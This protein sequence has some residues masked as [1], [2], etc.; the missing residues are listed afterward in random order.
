[1]LTAGIATG[2]ATLAVRH[3]A[4]R[5]ADAAADHADARARI[6]ARIAAGSAAD[7]ASA[8]A[9]ASATAA[10]A[11]AHASAVS[12]ADADAAAADAAT[13]AGSAHAHRD[14]DFPPDAMLRQPLWHDTGPPDGLRPA[15]IGDTLLDTDPR[16]AFFK[17][18]HDGMDGG[19][20]V[21]PELCLR[22][23]T[24][25]PRE[26]WE[27][28][29]D[30]VAQAI[31]DIEAAWLSEHAANADRAPAFEPDSVAHVFENRIIVSAGLSSLAT[32]IRQEFERFR[33]ETGLN[34]TP[35]MFTPLEALP[36]RLD[37]ISEILQT[38]Q[39]S[40]ETEQTLR[41]EIGRLQ[42]KL[43]ELEA[44][45]A[46]ARTNCEKLRNSS[47]KKVAAYTVAGA[48]LFGVI[49]AA[50]WTVSGDEVGAK[51]RLENLQ[52]YPEVLFGQGPPSDQG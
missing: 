23:A 46:Q 29:A 26:T 5:A 28:G 40:R 33:A 39:Q 6:A 41:E 13:A 44:H 36:P 42:A 30:A 14:A 50:L 10:D 48:N 1:M 35:E 12:A 27:S 34:E 38:L 20:P 2:G 24:K 32:T 19:T 7:A 22:I 17:R 51:K 45:L 37:R 16:F 49:A 3:A 31:A 4:A 25:I 11:A 8:A 9:A 18:W 21:P 52:E 43:A 15:D 47:W